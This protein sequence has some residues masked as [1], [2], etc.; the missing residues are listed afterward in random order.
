MLMAFLQILE[1]STVVYIRQT[2]IDR[3]IFLP[4]AFSSIFLPV[5]F[6]YRDRFG[7]WSYDNIIANTN[8]NDR[9]NLAGFVFGFSRYG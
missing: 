5:Q 4:F 1:K 7:L 6:K 8:C 9:L 3:E 2:Q